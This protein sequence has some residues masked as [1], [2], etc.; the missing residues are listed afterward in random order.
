MGPK[1]NS[2]SK[3]SSEQERNLP[4]RSTTALLENKVRR[5]NSL[6]RTAASRVVAPC[7]FFSIQEGLNI[8]LAIQYLVHY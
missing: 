2:G 8:I 1:N 7:A 3:K 5:M 6:K 4:N